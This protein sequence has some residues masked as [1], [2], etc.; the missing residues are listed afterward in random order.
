MSYFLSICIPTYNGGDNLKYNVNKLIK[1]QP[2]YGFEICVSDNA[3]DDGTQEFISTAASEYEFI[4]YHK[5]KE[6]MGIAY[7]FDYVLNMA[8]GEYRW[9]LGDDDE[10]VEENLGKVIQSL[11]EHMPDIC[12]VNGGT[13]QYKY[14]VREMET[15]LFKDKNAVFSILGEHM[16][17]I[18][19]LVM[20]KTFV[21]QI[22]IRQVT[23]NAFPHIIEVFK[24]LDKCCNLLWIYDSCVHMQSNNQNRYSEHYLDYFIKDWVK[25]TEQIGHY[26]KEAKSNFCKIGDQRLFSFKSIL[27][28]RARNI[29]NK[30][31]VEKCRNELN[32]FSH[33][34]KYTIYLVNFLPLSIF[35]IIYKL[36]KIL[37]GV[38]NEKNIGYTFL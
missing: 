10:I 25:V 13:K 1:M 8:S 3:S 4:K 27:S 2:E 14:R 24:Q 38:K 12:V 6:N 35:K 33:K 36:Y 28:L 30:K 21:R 15:K 37:K 7:N 23:T 29:I 31:S 18:S 26:S 16:T 19:C 9:L 34:T 20:S 11:K 5:N 17:W 22:N 32:Y